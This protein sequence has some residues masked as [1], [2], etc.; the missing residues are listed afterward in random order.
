MIS[1]SYSTSAVSALF[2]SHALALC[3]LASPANAQDFTSQDSKASDA[4]QSGDIIVT[5][6]KRAQT[7]NKVSIAVTALSEQQLNDAGVVTIRDL[8]SA[9]PNVQVHTIGPVGFSGVSVRGISNQD[10]SQLGSPA[11]A[12]YVDGVYV[13]VSQAMTGGLYDI[14]RMEVLRGPQGTTY[15]QNATGGNVNIIT[16]DPKHAFGASADVSYG[17]YNDV[18]AHAMVNLPV[19]GTLAIRGAVMLHRSDGYFNTEGTTS[20]NYAAADEFGGRLTALWTPSSNF[21][22]KLI[23]EKFVNKGTPSNMLMQEGPDG[24]PINGRSP[25]SQPFNGPHPD[26]AIDLKGFSIRSRIDWTIADGLSLAYTAGYQH[27]NSTFIFGIVGQGGNESYDGDW[28]DRVKAY[29]NEVDLT[30]DRGRFH[31]ILGASQFSKTNPFEK[32]FHFYALGVDIFTPGAARQTSVGIFDQATYSVLDNVRLIGGIRRSHETQNT[33]QSYN[34]TI[35][36]IPSGSPLEFSQIFAFN[37]ASASCSVVA[38][39]YAKG[40]WTNTSW[41]GGVEWDL[42]A[43]TLAYFTVTNGFKSGQVQPGLPAALP[44]SVSPEEVINYEL[45]LKSRLFDNRLNIRIAAFNEDYKN[46]QVSKVTTLGTPPSP[47][48]FSQNAG[49]ARIYGAELEATLAISPR[50]HLSGFA[51]YTHATYTDYL[52]AYDGQTGA[53]IASLHGRFLPNAPEFSARLQ[54]SH[55]FEM[56]LGTITPL[57]AVYYQSKSYLRE[58]NYAIDR[59]GA[60]T[61]TNLSLTYTD[62]SDHWTASAYVDNLENHAIRNSGNTAVSSYFSDYQPPRQYG[63]R[64]GYKF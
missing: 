51:S 7:V 49:G 55:D 31:N 52:N 16:P 22:W 64:I 10:F 56:P 63:L 59:V 18:Q 21:K 30:F 54:Y 42:T 40:A 61:K 38:I 20:R 50:D 9:V 43:R 8:T 17:N 36:G 15:G 47:Y 34:E 48:V 5:A 45:G 44:A 12:T 26:P 25:F 3:L 62:K 28:I 53:V 11:V 33:K 35:C 46:I 23:V 2:L 29:S 14:D 13:A 4:P 27:Q 19:S 58:F 39:P 24:K 6:Q 37:S 41:K 1:R 32:A 57:A 60:Y